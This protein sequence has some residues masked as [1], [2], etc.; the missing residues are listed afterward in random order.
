MHL[1][2]N[3]QKQFNKVCER[4]AAGASLRAVCQEDSTLPT[5]ETIRAWLSEEEDGELSAQYAQ[6]REEQAESH[7]G[8]LLRI[9]DDQSIDPQS[10][11]IMVDA[12]K[13]IASKLKPRVYGD[14]IDHKHSGALTI[15]IRQNDRVPDE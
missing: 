8:E 12:R 13:W 2:K 1:N 9:A 14:K 6:A 11:K 5:R 7:T 15:G 3:Q 10:R 4:I